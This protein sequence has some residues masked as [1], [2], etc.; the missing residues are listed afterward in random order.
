M[1]NQLN[2]MPAEHLII[3]A[4]VRSYKQATASDFKS[5][6]CKQIEIVYNKILYSPKPMLDGMEMII[7]VKALR[8]KANWFMLLKKEAESVLYLE[9]SNKIDL[10]RQGFQERNNPLRNRKAAS[11]P[12]LTA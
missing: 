3:V 5:F 9:L 7:I 11:A 10:E 12:T 1:K 8:R 6:L 2:L 4:A